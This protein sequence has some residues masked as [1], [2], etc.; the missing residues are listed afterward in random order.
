LTE[1]PGSSFATVWSAV[2]SELNGE[3]ATDSAALMSPFGPSRHL[4]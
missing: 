3:L 1:D 2:V 4:P